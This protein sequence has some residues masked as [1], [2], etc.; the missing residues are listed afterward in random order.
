MDRNK[1]KNKVPYHPDESNAQGI[2]NRGYRKVD[3]ENKFKRDQVPSQQMDHVKQQYDSLKRDL[4]QQQ[5]SKKLLDQINRWE[6]DSIETI[7]SVAR[8]ARADVK[9]IVDPS[10]SRLTSSISTLSKELNRKRKS[11]DYAD[12]DI[13]RW[14]LALTKYHH[15]LDKIL[16]IRITQENLSSFPLL[17]IE[18]TNTVDNETIDSAPEDV[19]YSEIKSRETNECSIL[20]QDDYPPKNIQKLPILTAATISSPQY[21]YSSVYF[22]ATKSNHPKIQQLFEQLKALRPMDKTG[23]MSGDCD[24]ETTQMETFLSKT[25]GF[26]NIDGK[27]IVQG[28]K[29]FQLGKSL[30]TMKPNNI[31]RFP[32]KVADSFAMSVQEIIDWQR[33]Y[34]VYADKTIKGMSKE[35]LLHALRGLSRYGEEA[36]RMKF[37]VRISQCPIL[38]EFDARII[39]R[40]PTESWPNRIKLVSVTGIDFAGRI[41]DADDIRTYVSNWPDVYEI[42]PRKKLPLVYNGRD[43]RRRHNG[44]RGKLDEERVRDDLMRMARLR[45]RACDREKVEI[46]VETGIGLGVFA[47]R[48]IG[49]DEI[50]RSLSAFAIRRVLEEDGSSYRHIRGIVFALPMFDDDQ[51]NGRRQETYHAFVDA[52]SKDKYQ[53]P[54]PVLV[55]DQ[56]MHRLTV[57]IARLGFTVSE[58]NPADSHGVFGEYWQNRGPAV[59]EKLA[60]TTMGLLV[61]HHLI[62]PQV[63]DPNHYYLI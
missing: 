47:G 1:N 24:F 13:A 41:H 23:S 62:N 48:G 10:I 37:V 58:L 30:N 59:E 21:L 20:P 53:G 57:A 49:I 7:K 16:A 51:Q 55:A 18:N 14:K 27:D 19:V 28:V 12:T 52:F 35:F 38:M 2:D 43:F 50:V 22:C 32:H 40:E 36:F 25:F 29:A 31:I 44:P 45:L 54:I 9:K 11:N 26:M 61:Q 15:E 60:L 4:H 56:D 63:L 39:P 42:D 34:A 8:R 5:V 46:V 3:V 33:S 17:T 6:T